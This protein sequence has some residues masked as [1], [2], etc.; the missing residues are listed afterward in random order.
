MI[1]G[2]LHNLRQLLSCASFR[3]VMVY[4]WTC[5]MSSGGLS[6]DSMVDSMALLTEISTIDLD[7]F[8]QVEKCWSVNIVLVVTIQDD[9]ILYQA[10][11]SMEEIL[12]NS[13][14]SNSGSTNVFDK[15]LNE[16]SQTHHCGGD[17]DHLWMELNNLVKPL[18]PS[19]TFSWG[20]NNEMRY[21]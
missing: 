12:K 2:S 1:G 7:R 21:F 14:T 11:Q 17:P 20:S 9:F 19:L 13:S 18:R 10:N 16:T 4:F 8:F 5:G 3:R 15:V 6:F